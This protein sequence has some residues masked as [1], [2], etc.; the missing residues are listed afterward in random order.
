MQLLLPVFQILF[1]PL[2]DLHLVFVHFHL[3]LQ[4][5]VVLVQI[6][7]VLDFSVQLLPQ[8]VFFSLQSHQVVHML[9]DLLFQFVYLFR[10]SQ[11][12]FKLPVV[13]V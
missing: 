9:R 8:L 11:R 4:L 7:F 12:A 6:V 10:S 1:E 3:L 5:L 13:L 2:V